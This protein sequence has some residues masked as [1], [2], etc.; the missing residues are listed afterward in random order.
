MGAPAPAA[1]SSKRRPSGD[2][3][4]VASEDMGAILFWVIEGREVG[5]LPDGA[6]K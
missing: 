5:K 4:G 2:D 3:T 1:G 6:E